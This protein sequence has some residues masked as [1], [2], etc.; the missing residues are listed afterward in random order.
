MS[1]AWSST[2]ADQASPHRQRC[3]GELQRQASPGVSERTLVLV[4]GRCAGQDQ[5][6]A[7]GLQRES[8]PLC[9]GV[10]DTCRIRPPLLPAG[11]NGN[12]R[13]AGSFYFRAVLIRV[14]GHC[15]AQYERRADRHGDS[16]AGATAKAAGA[17]LHRTCQID[18]QR[19]SI[20]F[21]AVKPRDGGLRFRR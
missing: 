10:S 8:S 9:A 2:S 3:R 5:G 15:Q 4:I 18:G 14:Q 13:R 6:L 21:L 16:V 1:T 12:V 19:T 11:S 17:R 20:N 7:S